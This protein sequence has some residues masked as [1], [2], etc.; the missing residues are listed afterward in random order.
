MNQM[1]F[2]G[3][4]THLSKPQTK[5]SNPRTPRPSPTKLTQI[6]FDMPHNR[7]LILRHNSTPKLFTENFGFFICTSLAIKTFYGSDFRDI[8]L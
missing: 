5:N 3:N 2:S 6:N 1:D 4:A 7:R 8:Y